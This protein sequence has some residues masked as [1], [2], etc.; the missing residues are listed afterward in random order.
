[1]FYYERQIEALREEYHALSSRVTEVTEQETSFQE[2]SKKVQHQYAE[3]QDECEDTKVARGS[4]T[5]SLASLAL[6]F[7]SL[8]IPLMFTCSVVIIGYKISSIC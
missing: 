8:H 7:H 6:L 1:M 5:P 3:L 2:N 4:P